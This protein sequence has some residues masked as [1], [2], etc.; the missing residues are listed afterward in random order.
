MAWFNYASDVPNPN[1]NKFTSAFLPHELSTARAALGRTV[2]V[3]HQRGRDAPV[4]ERSGHADLAVEHQRRK[5]DPGRCLPRRASPSASA[6]WAFDMLSGGQSA[7]VANNL[8]L[9]TNDTDRQA[10]I[11]NVLT[12]LVTAL[13]GYHGL[14]SWE[15]FNEPEG[16]TTQNG[17]TTGNGAPAGGQEVDESVIQGRRPTGLP[18]LI[19]TADPNALVTVGAWT[20][21]ANSPVVGTNYYSDAALTAA[22]G[23]SKGTLDYYQVHYYDN[24]GSP[25][26]A[27]KVSPF[28]NAVSHW[29]L[30]DGPKPVVIGDFWD[31]DTYANG[32]SATISSANLYTTLYTN[33]YSGAWA[34]QYANADNPGPADYPTNGE[35]TSW[36]PL[37]HG[38]RSKTFIMRTSRP[39]SAI[40]ERY[41]KAGH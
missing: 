18:T 20:F 33:N 23:R 35:Q 26:A 29:G 39:S 19:H 40:D 22:G 36:G 11:M 34:W 38:R 10:Y 8:N 14:Y 41:G 24:W 25:G 6:L 1:I 32:T 5:E 21:L 27:E 37:M 13:K 17:W 2:V 12:P 7:P 31:I 4:H 28:Q 3:S 16:M 15:I 30:T 9:L